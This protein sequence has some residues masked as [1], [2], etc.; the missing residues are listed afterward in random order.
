VKGAELASLEIRPDGRRDPG[1]GGMQIHQY[2]FNETTFA[3]GR[4]S[5]L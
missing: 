4:N 2:R 3:E 5:W 1:D